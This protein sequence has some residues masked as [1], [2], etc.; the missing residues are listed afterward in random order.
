VKLS[1]LTYFI[2][3]PVLIFAQP[4]FEDITKSSQNYIHENTT[5]QVRTVIKNQLPNVSTRTIASKSKI[6]ILLPSK[7]IG[8]YATSTTNALFAY[9]ISKN[10]PFEIKTFEIENQDSSS[11]S[12]ALEAIAS[13]GFSYVIAPLTKDGVEKLNALNPKINIFIPTINKSEFAL[14]SSNLI[15][16]GIDYKMQIDVLVKEAHKPLVIF[17]DGS[18]VSESLSEYTQKITPVKSF[19]FTIDKNSNIKKFLHRSSQLKHASF[20]TNT[21]I[22]KTGV[23]LSQITLYDMAASNI[24]STQINYDPMILSMTQ[25]NDRKNMIIANSI[26]RE[27]SEVTDANLLLNNDVVY[28]WINYS[29]TVGIDYFYSRITGQARMYP[30]PILNNQIIYPI[31][32]VKPSLASFVNYK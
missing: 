17:K 10:S 25:I 29:T 31:S 4:S 22:V 15:F 3:I 2:S 26:S 30:L 1:I 27:S 32:L 14:T 6:A 5:T 18:P 24:L 11:I 8:R 21:P 9:M 28:D 20:L 19:A 23:I 13:Q 16:G 7:Q 12:T